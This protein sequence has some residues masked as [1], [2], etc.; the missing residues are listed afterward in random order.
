MRKIALVGDIGSGKTF[1][2]KLF[3][4]PVFNADLEVS[5]LYQK[6]KFLFRKIK[7]KFPN[8]ISNFPLK[9]KEL[10]KII[11]HKQKNLNVL[12]KI[13]HPI[14]RKKIKNFFKANIKK[15]FVVLDVPLFLENKLNNKKDIIIFVEADKKKIKQ[16]LNKRKNINLKLINILRK[17]QLPSR[18]KKEKSTYIIKNNFVRN[19]ARKN[20][21]MIL[22]K[23]SK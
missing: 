16:K 13:I 12:G 22:K 5:N 11:F 23:I 21:K 7:K 10:H 9:K 1:F 14:I 8:Q 4:Y 20:V 15:K 6:N 3:R 17:N 2:S 19:T 18:L